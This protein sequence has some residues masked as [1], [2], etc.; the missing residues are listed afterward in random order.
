MY[1]TAA[2][3]A[4][5]DRARV[6][7]GQPGR[8]LEVGCEGGRWSRQLSGVGWSVVCTDVD[9]QALDVCRARIPDAE[10][11][12]MDPDDEVLPC[13]D[14]SVR[15]LVAFEV[16]PVTRRTSFP[17]EA[18][19]VLEP[20]GVLVCTYYNSHSARGLAYRALLHLGGD[21]KR[22]GAG[23]YGGPS[24]RSFRRR[25]RSHR[26]LLTDEVGLGWA[27]F[28]RRS[29]SRL[30]PLAVGAE[31]LLRLRSLPTL[32]PFVVLVARRV[33]DVDAGS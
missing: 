32:S 5:L 12:L 33:D 2:E 25:L 30:I 28:R 24:Y 22:N 10:T 29:D 7:A 1:L 9:D 19:R 6:L 3:S 23:Y 16:D 8:A 15:L 20:G 4:A 27:P 11:V 13:A 26:L 17:A 18:S 21:R 31:K 14:A